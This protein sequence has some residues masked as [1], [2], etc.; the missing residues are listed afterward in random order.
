[1][2]LETK[3]LIIRDYEGSDR[4]NYF[5]LKN[6]AKTMYYLQDIKFSSRQESD[7]E[8]EQI[9]DDARKKKRAMNR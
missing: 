1:M 2:Y 7:E 5:R 9:L 8:F 4:D 6:D 3:R